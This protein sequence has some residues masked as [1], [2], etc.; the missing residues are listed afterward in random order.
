MALVGDPFVGCGLVAIILASELLLL[1]F[2]RKEASVL[3]RSKVVL[4]VFC[5]YHVLGSRGFLRVD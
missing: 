4:S 5:A 3:Q 1:V 2:S